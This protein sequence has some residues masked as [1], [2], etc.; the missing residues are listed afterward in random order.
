[1]IQKKL[2]LTIFTTIALFFC[3]QTKAQLFISSA[4]FFIQPGATVTVQGN[5]TSNTAIQGTGLVVL[6]GTSNQTVDMG[7]FAI[8]NL[9]INNAANATLLSNLL[10]SD[11]LYLTSGK[12]T[13]GSN[14]LTLAAAAG[15][16]GGGIGTFIE[17]NSTGQAVKD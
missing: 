8:P 1:M 14:N 16:V 6:N 5:I 10:I 13:L 9:Q 11:S 15:T 2:P 7:G 17:T 12:I 4:T 3:S